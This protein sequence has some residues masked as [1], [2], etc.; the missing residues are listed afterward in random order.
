MIVLNLSSSSEKIIVTL[1]EKSTVENPTY[2]FTFTNVTTKSD[3]VTFTSTDLSNYKNRFNEFEI[4]TAS[5]FANKNAGQ[6][7]YVVT[8]IETNTI[9]ENGKMKLINATTI[10]QGYE[11][12]TT[13]KGYAG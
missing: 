9:V 2:L 1:T 5:V 12:T 10:K 8:E 3:V 11:P 7:D 6:W 4:N 13:I